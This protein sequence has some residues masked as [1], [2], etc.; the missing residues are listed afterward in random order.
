MF[1]VFRLGHAAL[2]AG[3][4]VACAGAAFAPA[5]ASAAQVCGDRAKMVA[6]LGKDYRELPAGI[7]LTAGG[8]VIELFTAETGSWTIL[9]T[10]PG[11]RTCVT[12]IGEGW[13][14]TPGRWPA[15]GE[16]S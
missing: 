12:S 2:L 13:E 14:H 8:A 11:G 7:G 5:P 9:M 16:A 10:M 1:K 3:L 15:V 6:H 4:L